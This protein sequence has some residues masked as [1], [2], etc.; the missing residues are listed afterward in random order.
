MSKKHVVQ[1][2]A[3]NS[4]YVYSGSLSQLFRLLTLSGTI[5]PVLVG[6]GVAALTGDIRI[7]LLIGM[8]IASVFVQTAAN[9]LNDYFDFL[10]GQDKEKWVKREDSNHTHDIHLKTLPF[11][12]GIL[13]I[14]A[15]VIGIWLALESNLWILV[16][17]AISI[18]FSYLYS[19]G[20]R[21]LSSIGFGETIAAVFLGIMVTNL[22]YIIQGNA[23]DS[24]ILL[25]S[26]VFSLLIATMILT[27][28]IRDIQK[29]AAFRK[30]SAIMLGRKP[31]VTL[32]I[33]LLSM[34]YIWSFLLMIIGL[35]PWYALLIIL[36]LPRAKQLTQAL[37]QDATRQEEMLG[38]KWAALH[39]WTFGILLAL[40]VWL[41]VGLG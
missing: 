25:I 15:T 12:A 7:D 30:T 22:S 16:A 3:V 40:G 36:A 32:L 13:L 2:Q 19:G 1:S 17:G 27:N 28:N 5:S 33:S 6:T 9:I 37:K 18:L 14:F 23:L 8:L 20:P 31:A 34:T 4:Q 24:R 11:I 29:D 38:M 35:L 39:H 41:S 21:P 26:I 10:N